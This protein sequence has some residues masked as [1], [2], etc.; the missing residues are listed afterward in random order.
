MKLL[1]LVLTLILM[2]S[3]RSGDWIITKVGEKEALTM[4]MRTMKGKGSNGNDGSDGSHGSNGND[5]GNGN[6]NGNGIIIVQPSNIIN[7]A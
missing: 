2:N 7:F 4:M 1:I 5:G 6:N 3:L